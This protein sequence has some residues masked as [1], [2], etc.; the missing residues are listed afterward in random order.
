MDSLSSKVLGELFNHGSRWLLNLRRAKGERKQASVT[1]LRKVITSSR[2]T[3]VYIRQLNDSGERD[4][5]TERHLSVLWTELGFALEDLGILK[6]A[7]R[8]QIKGKHWSNPSHYDK[9]FLDKADVSLDR[10]ERVAR[11]VLAEINH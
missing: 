5:N 3:A 10:M 8:C 4:H 11:E 1:A 2:E 9:D 7:K 6:L